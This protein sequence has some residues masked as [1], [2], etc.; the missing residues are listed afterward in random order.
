MVN[1][2]SLDNLITPQELNARLTPE[3]RSLNA[4]IAGKASGEARSLKRNLQRWAED[5][6]YEKMVE[7]A[8]SHLENP[9]FWEM[10]ASILGEGPTQRVE[11][12]VTQNVIQVT[13]DD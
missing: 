9:R 4:S 10:V 13:V 11:A 7:V 3:E 6:G 1:D 8:D 5:G 2:R 12:D